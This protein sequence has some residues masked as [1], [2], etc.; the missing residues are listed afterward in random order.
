MPLQNPEWVPEGGTVWD[1]DLGLGLRRSFNYSVKGRLWDEL[2][3]ITDID[4]QKSIITLPRYT[5]KVALAYYAASK[6]KGQ[7]L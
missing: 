4:T 3:A 2:A 7:A 5:T 6:N 1:G